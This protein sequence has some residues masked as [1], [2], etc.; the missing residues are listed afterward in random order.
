LEMFVAAFSCAAVHEEKLTDE[1]EFEMAISAVEVI[2]YE[3]SVVR[4]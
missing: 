1:L 4:G 3:R 2:L